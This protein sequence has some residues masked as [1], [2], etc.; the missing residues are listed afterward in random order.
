MVLLIA[1]GRLA[2]VLPRLMR[3]TMTSCHGWHDGAAS[4]PNKTGRDR[5]PL[6]LQPK[7]EVRLNRIRL[8]SLHGHHAKYPSSSYI[9]VR[10]HEDSIAW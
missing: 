10:S 4:L 5:V 7:L 1:P 6:A 9:F 8:G 3:R 2:A